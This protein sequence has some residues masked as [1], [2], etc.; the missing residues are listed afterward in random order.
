MTVHVPVPVHAHVH[1]HVPLPQRLPSLCMCVYEFAC[2]GVFA[3]ASACHP[4][5]DF[6]TPL[7]IGAAAHTV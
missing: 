3:S 5:A 2:V 7:T 1:A 6:F 4:T